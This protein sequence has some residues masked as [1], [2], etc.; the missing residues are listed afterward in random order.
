MGSKGAPSFFLQSVGIK[1]QFWTLAEIVF[2]LNWTKCRGIAA[3]SFNLF[4]GHC[5]PNCDIV[6]STYS[7]HLGDKRI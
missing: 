3:A 6:A 5:C 1:D 2:W 7:V 4:D